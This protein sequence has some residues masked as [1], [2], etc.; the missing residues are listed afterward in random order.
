MRRLLK[1]FGWLIGGLAVLAVGLWIFGP[2]E[3][4]DTG[5]DF[6]AATVP[7]DVDGWLA[8]REG[9]VPDVSPDHTKRVLWAGAPG[10]R[11]DLVLVY[12]H[13]F[14]ATLWETRP[15]A[16][17]LG[18][19]LGA[20]VFYTRLAGH[21]RDGAAMAEPQAGDWVE[22]LAEAMAVAE[23]L[24]DRVVVIGTSTGGTLAAL[25]AAE[26]ALEALRDDL[27][28]VIFISPNFRVVNPAAR[29]LS[30][31]AARHWAPL[32]AGETRSFE[33]L[34]ARHARH[35][36]TE[37]PT[38]ALLPMQALID[39]AAALDYAVAEVP[40]LFWYA[41]ADQVVDAAA[42]RAVT[43]EWGGTATTREIDVHPDDDPYSH[44]IAGDILSPAGTPGAIAAMTDWLRGL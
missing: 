31:P 16:D 10:T 34:N 18:E 11:S 5:V 21:G 7:D 28:G 13:G 6:D 3:E 9:R 39:H 25:L 27:A 30:M 2:Y 37:Y 20:N 40:A 19:E 44:V 32:V 41:P 1:G 22:D 29:L 24:G 38:R 12:L 36:T 23:K 8:D 33:A 43:S 35:W 17:R 26:P 4:V 42:T 15:L 14:S